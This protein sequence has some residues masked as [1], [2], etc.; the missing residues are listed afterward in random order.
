MPRKNLTSTEKAALQQLWDEGMTTG[1]RKDLIEKAI[2]Q[3]GLDEKTIMVL[4]THYKRLNYSPHDRRSGRDGTSS[5]V[6]RL[7]GLEII[8]KKMGMAVKRGSRKE[9]SQIRLP[10]NVRKRSAYCTFKKEFLSSDKAK[11]LR[12]EG[13]AE[14]EIQKQ[15]SAEYRQLSPNSKE[16]Y[17]NSAEAINATLPES[18]GIPKKRWSMKQLDQLGCPSLWLGY[19]GRLPERLYSPALKDLGEDEVFTNYVVSAIV[20]KLARSQMEKACG[21]KVA[22]KSS[23]GQTDK[24]RLRG[25]ETVSK[26]RKTTVELEYFYN[27]LAYIDENDRLQLSN[28]QQ[29]QDQPARVGDNV[30]IFN[31][32]G[33]KVGDGQVTDQTIVHGYELKEG[34][35][36]LMVLDI[37]PG[38][39]SQSNYPTS[40]GLVEK[41]S[42]VAWPRESI[43]PKN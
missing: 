2:E 24:T 3:I 35:I 33:E 28:V 25:S 12:E 5:Q 37:V 40:S 41:N 7:P 22:K 14:S 8:K 11:K 34:W 32:S 21:T 42:F 9:S 19:S 15:G 10:G 20:N 43:G 4:Q 38:V 29:P 23:G 16:K 30:S 13:V 18:T 36:P 27:F 6:D 17:A 39:K 31:A 26:P 1:K